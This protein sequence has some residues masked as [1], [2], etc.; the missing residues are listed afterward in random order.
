MVMVVMV[1]MM[2]DGGD[3]ALYD[4]FSIPLRS[5][6]DPRRCDEEYGSFLFSFGR[7]WRRLRGLLD[8]L[9]PVLGVSWFV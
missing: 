9:R 7:A 1:L 5:R 6:F 2:I 4:A 8:R 3:D